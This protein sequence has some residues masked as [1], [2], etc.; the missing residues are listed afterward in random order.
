MPALYSRWVTE[1]P[2]RPSQ[3]TQIARLRATR[4]KVAI[5]VGAVFAFLVAMVFARISYAGHAKQ[6]S[7]SLT[8]PQR[9][10]DI[11][12]QS[13]LQSGIVAPPQ[14]DPGAATATS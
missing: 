13:Q 12:R 1:P 3:R 10:L 7:T 6:H 4:V 8:P 11:V 14:A 5:A 9:F 2:R